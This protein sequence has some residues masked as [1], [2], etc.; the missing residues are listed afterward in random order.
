[1]WLSDAVSTHVSHS[2]IIVFEISIGVLRVLT[3]AGEK[4]VEERYICTQV[5]DAC[6]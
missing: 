1:M 2:A 4:E 6:I 5:R 3:P